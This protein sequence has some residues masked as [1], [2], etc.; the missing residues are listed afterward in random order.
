M[1]HDAL[2][3]AMVERAGWML[4]P[5]SKLHKIAAQAR[6]EARRAGRDPGGRAAGPCRACGKRTNQHDVL[7]VQYRDD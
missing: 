6:H 1:G 7:R 2:E 4:D 3:H 5:G